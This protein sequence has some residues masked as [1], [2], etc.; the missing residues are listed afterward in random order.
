MDLS[1]IT[2]TV[3]GI[4]CI[5]NINS[6][7]EHTWLKMEETQLPNSTTKTGTVVGEHS[8]TQP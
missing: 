6:T 3:I 1:L 5:V 4:L 8:I 7:M 2:H